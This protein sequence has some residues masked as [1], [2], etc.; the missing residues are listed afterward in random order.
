MTKLSCVWI[1]WK[2][3][4]LHWWSGQELCTEYSH[5]EKEN[6]YIGADLGSERT[7]KMEIF[8]AHRYHKEAY[9]GYPALPQTSKVESFAKIVNN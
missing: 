3:R 1:F 9:P 8:V 5:F 2:G 4:L 7:S 6:H